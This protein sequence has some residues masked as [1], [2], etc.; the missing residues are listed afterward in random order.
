MI[1]RINTSDARWRWDSSSGLITTTTNGRGRWWSSR[2][3]TR[4]IGD[5]NYRSGEGLDCRIIVAGN[6]SSPRI[7][8]IRRYESGPLSRAPCKQ[9]VSGFDTSEWVLWGLFRL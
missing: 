4:N 6:S 1:R 5:G 8:C 7:G 2:S 9:I 3:V